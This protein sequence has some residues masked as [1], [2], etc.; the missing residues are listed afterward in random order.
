MGHAHHQAGDLAGDH[1]CPRLHLRRTTCT[2]RGMVVLFS[3]TT[4]L[5]GSDVSVTSRDPH[6]GHALSSGLGLLVMKPG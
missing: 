4:A 6:S 1:T 3:G 5:S 2:G